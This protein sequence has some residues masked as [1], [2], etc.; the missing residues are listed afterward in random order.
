MRSIRWISTSE[1]M[2]QFAEDEVRERWGVVGSRRAG[3]T[4]RDHP[5]DFIGNPLFHAQLA[6]QH[7]CVGF[8]AVVEC[9]FTASRTRPNGTCC[10]FRVRTCSSIV[11]FN[12]SKVSTC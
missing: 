6:E 4:A 11:T 10:A 5:V 1:C 3:A 7:V 9:T 12:M 2:R 8:G